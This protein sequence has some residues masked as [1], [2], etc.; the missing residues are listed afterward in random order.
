MEGFTSRK[1]CH[2]SKR[3]DFRK[4]Y[5]EEEEK[6]KEEEGEDGDDNVLLSSILVID[7][8][9]RNLGIF[10]LEI[11][12]EK[13]ELRKKSQTLDLGISKS[14][15][16]REIE[17]ALDSVL[18]DFFGKLLKRIDLLVMERQPSKFPANRELQIV[19]NT[20]FNIKYKVW[21]TYLLSPVAVKNKLGLPLSKDHSKNKFLMQECIRTNEN[22]LFH[23][24]YDSHIADCVG[25][26]N[27]FL[28]S[29][30]R[31]SKL[32]NFYREK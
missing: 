26:L 1:S 19:L 11:D 3:A 21:A 17:L 12:Y 27:V 20:Y 18:P 8:G 5:R 15:T 31:I 14:A 6:K 22:L 29:H 30:K 24:D 23:G 13:E 9:W 16:P 2:K 25:L 10:L 28:Q 7:P 4:I 32:V